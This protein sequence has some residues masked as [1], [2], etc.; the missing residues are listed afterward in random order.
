ML[1]C[2]VCKVCTLYQLVYSLCVPADFSFMKVMAGLLRRSRERGGGRNWELGG[3]WWMYRA[4]SYQARGANKQHW[5]HL[6]AATP[7]LLVL[8]SVSLLRRMNNTHTHRTVAA[9]THPSNGDEFSFLSSSLSL[10]L[11]LSLSLCIHFFLILNALMT[12]QIV[13]VRRKEHLYYIVHNV[14]TIEPEIWNSFWGRNIISSHW[15]CQ[16]ILCRRARHSL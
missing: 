11:S 15:P 5:R 7:L 13:T 3:T 16:Y 14:L 12:T 9:T 1:R 2:C 4:I 8:K 10:F 6:Q